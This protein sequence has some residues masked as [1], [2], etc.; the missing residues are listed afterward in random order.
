MRADIAVGERAEDRIDQRVQHDIG[1][2]MAGQSAIMRD[3]HAAQRHVI[4]VAEG[5][6]VEAHAGADVGQLLEQHRFGPA[7]NRRAW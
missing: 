2:R 4:A 6:H 7:G 3:P 5:V 1:I